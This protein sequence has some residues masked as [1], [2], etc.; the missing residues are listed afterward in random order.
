MMND[1]VPALP[2]EGH[3]RRGQILNPINSLWLLHPRHGSPFQATMSVAVIT[4]RS[5]P[6]RVF[7]MML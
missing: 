1:E 2:E 5:P 7:F 3:S 6:K 4:P